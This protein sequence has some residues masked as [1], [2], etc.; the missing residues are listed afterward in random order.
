MT[1]NLVEIS[2]LKAIIDSPLVKEP[3]TVSVFDSAGFHAI[4]SGFQVLDFG[5]FVSGT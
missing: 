5:F 4:Y 1:R 2:S 3:K